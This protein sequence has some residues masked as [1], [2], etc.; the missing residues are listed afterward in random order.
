MIQ[1][2]TQMT[3]CRPTATRCVAGRRARGVGMV[4][5]LV[6]LVVLSIGLLG[7][8]NLHLGSLRVTQEGYFH[9]Q[10]TVLAQ[11]LIDRMRANRAGVVDG[12]YTRSAFAASD[13]APQ[14]APVVTA[15]S[16]AQ[17]DVALWLQRLAC[18]LPAGDAT[19]VQRAD[20]V[21]RLAVRWRGRDQD[22]E[23][24]SAFITESVEVQL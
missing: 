23:G 13:Q 14:C 1:Q 17:A 8:A 6:S 12:E 5:V 15:G 18:E 4:E 21:W 24:E 9:S 2:D 7:V 22:E 16:V 19:V 10:A 11:E 20:G 3:R